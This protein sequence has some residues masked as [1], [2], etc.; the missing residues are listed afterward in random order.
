MSS[1]NVY[2][3]E[4]PTFNNGMF[5]ERTSIITHRN[6]RECRL[7]RCHIKQVIQSNLL[8]ERTNINSCSICTKMAYSALI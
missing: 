8:M 3:I 7:W 5:A 6:P 2:H 1:I 4:N